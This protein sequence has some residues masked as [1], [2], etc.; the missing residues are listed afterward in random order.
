MSKR[1]KVPFPSFTANGKWGRSGVSPSLSKN[2][3]KLAK[4]FLKRE[5]IFVRKACQ[6]FRRFDKN[7]ILEKVLTF[8]LYRYSRRVTRSFSGQGKFL[9]IRALQ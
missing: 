2:I 6:V 7:Y 4:I 3:F 5:L 9:K 1:K 8:F